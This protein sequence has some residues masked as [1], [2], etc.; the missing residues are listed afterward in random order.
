MFNLALL[1]KASFFKLFEM[2]SS[3]LDSHRHQLGRKVMIWHDNTDNGVRSKH[4]QECT[5][6]PIPNLHGMK[7]GSNLTAAQLELFD[8]VRYLFKSVLIS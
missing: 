5:K 7:L 3:I 6:M 4:I 1:L 8:N 2:L